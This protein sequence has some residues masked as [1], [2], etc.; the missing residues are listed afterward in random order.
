MRESNGVEFRIG[1]TL[2]AELRRQAAQDFGIATLF[3]PARA[4]RREAGDEI[5]AHGRIR[6]RT[7]RVVNGDRLIFLGAEGERGIAQ[8]YFAH[9]HAQIRPAAVDI[10]FLRSG[11]RARDAFG[12]LFGLADEIGGQCVH[13]IVL[14]I[15]MDEAAGTALA[16][17]ASYAVTA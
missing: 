2:A 10:D 4:Q 9:G 7:G 3:D 14:A 13:G 12:K 5:D 16:I 11:N 15:K 17:E 8:R 1:R 6:V